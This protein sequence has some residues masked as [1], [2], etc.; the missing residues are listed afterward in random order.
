MRCVGNHSSGVGH[1]R[2]G[3]YPSRWHVSAMSDSSASRAGS[4]SRPA[5]PRATSS[6]S[7]AAAV[8]HAGSIPMPPA[9]SGAITCSTCPLPLRCPHPVSCLR[10]STS[11][12]SPN[13]RPSGVALP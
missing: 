3:S 2:E 9:F 12:L 7:A 4:P 8:H 6:H 5:S 13:A 1:V 10:S 11:S